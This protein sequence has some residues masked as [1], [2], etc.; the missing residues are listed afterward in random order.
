MY[1]HCLGFLQVPVRAPVRLRYRALV[2]GISEYNKSVGK[3]EGVPKDVEHVVKFL[4]SIDFKVIQALNCTQREL[5]SLVEE[6]VRSVK[7]GD[8]TFFYFSGHGTTAADENYILP[9]DFK[10]G[11]DPRKLAYPVY[12][13]VVQPLAEKSV[14]LNIVCLDC[15][16]KAAV[17]RSR[18]ESERLRELPGPIGSIMS[19]ACEP[20]GEAPDGGDQASFYSQE[21]V[22]SLRLHVEPVA[23]DDTSDAISVKRDLRNVFTKM[24]ITLSEGNLGDA[25]YSA[26]I[27]E[28]EPKL[29]EERAPEASSGGGGGDSGGGGR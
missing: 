26:N 16:R 11:D 28:F 15:C 20:R 24:S 3:L 29:F 4:E 1:E 21:L 9:V 17:A 5:I 7:A 12:Q 19:F 6:F 22:S 23:V 8:T 13:Y 14:R 25:W 18:G 2:V 10:R 27:R